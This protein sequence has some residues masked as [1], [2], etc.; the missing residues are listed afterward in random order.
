ML[1]NTNFGRLS[2]TLEPKLGTSFYNFRLGESDSLGQ[3]L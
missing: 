1:L 3:K 2:E